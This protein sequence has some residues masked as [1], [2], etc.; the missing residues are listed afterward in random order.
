MSRNWIFP[1]LFT[2]SC[3]VWEKKIHQ[4]N[5]DGIMILAPKKTPWHHLLD[6]DNKTDINYRCLKDI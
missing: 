5:Y 4:T 2:Q 3:Q 6:L 1:T